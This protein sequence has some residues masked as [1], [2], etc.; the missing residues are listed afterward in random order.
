MSS[1]S[2]PSS[3]VSRRWHTCPYEPA[4]GF[5]FHTLGTVF[6][7]SGKQ[8]VLRL[9]N[10]ASLRCTSSTVFAPSHHWGLFLPLVSASHLSSAF[11]VRQRFPTLHY[12]THLS[13]TA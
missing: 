1:T 9:T 6:N 12:G 10:S 8:K 4:T 11:S 3:T 5:V 13:L 2:K 7:L